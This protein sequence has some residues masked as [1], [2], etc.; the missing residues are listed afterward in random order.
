MKPFLPVL[1]ADTLLMPE[2]LQEIKTAAHVILLLQKLTA[3]TKVE[4]WRDGYRAYRLDVE[5]KVRPRGGW[6]AVQEVEEDACCEKLLCGTKRRVNMD[7]RSGGAGNRSASVLSVG[8]S[9][10]RTSALTSS[11]PHKRRSSKCCDSSSVLGRPRRAHV[12]VSLSEG[13]RAQSAGC[14]KRRAS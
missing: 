8:P 14:S 9:S 6:E 11:G 13:S 3:F 10:S 4:F 12:R 1:R 2:K 5:A 7:R